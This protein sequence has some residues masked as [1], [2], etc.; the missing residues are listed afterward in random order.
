MVSSSGQE[1][2]DLFD[3]G[4]LIRRMV[5]RRLDDSGTI[6]DIVQETLTRVLE[7]RGR[8]EQ[9]SLASYAAIIARN[10]IV[11][12][13]RRREVERRQAPRLFDPKHPETPEDLVLRDE[14]RKALVTALAPLSTRDRSLA[15]GHDAHG[16]S[17][18]ALG[19]R[20]DMS[21]GAVA[22]RL[23]RLR[24]ELRLNYVVA[25]R[26][27]KLPTAMCRPVLLALSARDLRRQ[28][29]LDAA[30][31]LLE[32]PTCASLSEPLLA[33]RRS[34][35][36][37][38][39]LGPLARVASWSRAHPGQA[40]VAGITVTAVVATMWPTS[41]PPPRPPER[42]DFALTLGGEPAFSERGGPNLKRHEGDRA[43]GKGVRVQSVTSDEGFWIGPKVGDRLW[44]HLRGR[45]E[46]SFQIRSGQ[47]LRFVGEVVRNHPG[48]VKELQISSEEGS[49]ELR[50]LRFHINVMRS[51]LKIVS[52]A[53]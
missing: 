5:E 11:S 50:R 34:L 23:T 44:V 40:A 52:T 47:S 14:D 2:V 28:R 3:L 39:P 38:L 33:R 22:T 21:A 13:E 46:S 18:T 12:Q 7:V 49:A 51:D 19:R 42:N 36:A 31:H 30:G 6:D 16:I 35:A 17:A 8:L 43:V 4:N 48:F 26:R 37:I 24:A 53:R 20:Y 29:V 45:G 27:A 32:C 41:P 1:E 10:L 15:V 25:L 9:R